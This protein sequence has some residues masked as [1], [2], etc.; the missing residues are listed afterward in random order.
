MNSS[1]TLTAAFCLTVVLA[2]V[3]VALLVFALGW[4]ALWAIGG[5]ALAF[6]IL[7]VA[8]DLLAAGRRSD[9]RSL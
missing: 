4:G 5:G 3:V 6:V 9:H 2:L 1:H 8:R 7:S